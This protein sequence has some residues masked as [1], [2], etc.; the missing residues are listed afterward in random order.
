[1]TVLTR[2][3]DVGEWPN[4]LEHV[5]AVLALDILHH[6]GEVLLALEVPKSQHTLGKIEPE[7]EISDGL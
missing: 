6:H 3:P 5:G 2:V 1:M 7:E 4:V